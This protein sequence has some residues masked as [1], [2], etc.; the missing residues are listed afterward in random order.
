MARRFV[1]ARG[2]EWEVWEVTSRRTLADRAPRPWVP[3]GAS[4]ESAALHFESATQS[5]LL[6]EYPS[7]WHALDE[8]E[9]AGLCAAAHLESPAAVRRIAVAF[10]DRR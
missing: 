2:T 3:E 4:A 9:L 6:T 8:S 5:R 7:W 1:D 10:A